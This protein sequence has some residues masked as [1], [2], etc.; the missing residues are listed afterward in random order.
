MRIQFLIVYLRYGAKD[1]L[2]LTSVFDLCLIASDQ[3]EIADELCSYR[4]I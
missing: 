3:N 2:H 4:F 1:H